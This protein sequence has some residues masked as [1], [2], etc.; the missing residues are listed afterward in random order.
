M[1]ESEILHALPA[2]RVAHI[3]EVSGDPH[4]TLRI[5]AGVPVS[6]T[7]PDLSH[8]SPADITLTVMQMGYVVAALSVSEL[9]TDYRY[10]ALFLGHRAIYHRQDTR[11]LAADCRMERLRPGTIDIGIISIND[12]GVLAAELMCGIPRQEPLAVKEQLIPAGEKVSQSLVNE[13]LAIYNAEVQSAVTAVGYDVESR[14]Y[15]A[16]VY[17]PP[18]AEIP[19]LSH[20]SARQMIQALMQAAYCGVGQQAYLGNFPLSYEEFLTRRL[21]FRTREHDLRYRKL[22]VAG[23]QSRLR[24]QLAPPLRNS[25]TVVFSHRPGVGKEEESFATGRM[26]FYLADA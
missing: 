2:Y 5:K 7:C 15:E 26:T 11:S 20:V 25:C 3:Q 16:A 24:F 19:D 13:I 10:Q 12:P 23:T 14:V 4:T 9:P 17:L 21:D 1:K 18:Y 22:L 8:T 6:V